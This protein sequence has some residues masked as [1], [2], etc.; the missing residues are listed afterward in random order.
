M[1]EIPK[2]EVSAEGTI[3]Y[4]TLVAQVEAK[5]A[6]EEGN[7]NPGR[8]TIIDLAFSKQN[9]IYG[10]VKTRLEGGTSKSD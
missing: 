9:K 6:G 8:L 10:E 5:E 7:I 2:A 3:V 1:A 4:G